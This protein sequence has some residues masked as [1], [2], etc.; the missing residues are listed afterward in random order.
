MDYHILFVHSPIGE[1]L[2]NFLDTDRH[3]PTWTL[4]I[5]K[6]AVM[7]IHIEFFLYGHIHFGAS[8]WLSGKESACQWKRHGLDPWVR[9]IS[10]RRGWNPLQ[11]SCLENPMDRGD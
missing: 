8:L 5:M 2:D 7:N 6:K 4:T 10:C 11:Y 1:R 9:K 3:S